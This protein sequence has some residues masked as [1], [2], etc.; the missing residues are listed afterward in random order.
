MSIGNFIKN[1]LMKSF[2][3]NDND[4]MPENILDGLDYSNAVV[5]I[6]SCVSAFDYFL[7]YQRNNV[8]TEAFGSGFFVSSEGHILTN[9]HV[10]R[11]TFSLSIK[12]KALGSE[13]LPVELVGICPSL[14]LALLKLTERSKAKIQKVLPE[15]P[16][17]PI[18]SSDE[19]RRGDK[20][21]TLGYPLGVDDLKITA[22]I[23]SGTQN[24]LLSDQEFL[25][26]AIQTDAAINFGNSGGPSINE[27]GECVGINFC[28]SVSTGVQNVGFVLPISLVKE[29]IEILKTEKIY[30]RLNLGLTYA[31]P[32]VPYLAEWMDLE[33]EGGL[34]VP[35][36]VEGSIAE[37]FGIKPGDTI[38]SLNGLKID[39]SGFV[40]TPWGEDK[41]YAFFVA[42]RLLRQEGLDLEVIRDGNLIKIEIPRLTPEIIEKTS[43]KIRFKFAE[44]EKL[45]AEIFGGC[46]FSELSLNQLFAP[47]TTPG[48]VL[49][50]AL[51]T[52]LNPGLL[53]TLKPENQTKNKIIV[54]AILNSSVAE[55][56]R[57]GIKPS[58]VLKSINGVLLEGL[59]DL[60][61]EISKSLVRKD[62]FVV[63]EFVEGYKFPL[64]LP[65]VI[66]D[67]DRLASIH[68]YSKDFSTVLAFLKRDS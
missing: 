21:I 3:L 47:Q 34:Y 38:I 45:E 11:N 42:D 43:P 36:V 46:V 31:Q 52:T 50:T 26:T 64:S 48:L 49:F 33:C 54:T 41:I 44:V 13:K 37:F 22:G 63:F 19:L 4:Q 32:V 62:K 12:I 18:G 16:V 57:V 56:S 61:R 30:R 60:S 35:S 8:K 59:S 14:D 1:G 39:T 9:Y 17:L 29:A 10:I 25:L 66:E 53:S 23:F 40:Q 2:G 27:K 7:P 6:E 24:I 65:D 28:V 5:K 55:S 51:G 20:I 15:I 67:E 58:M 68:G